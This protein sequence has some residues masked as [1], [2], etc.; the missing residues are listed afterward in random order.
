[1]FGNGRTATSGPGWC[2]IDGAFRNANNRAVSNVVIAT[3]GETS[4]GIVHTGGIAVSNSWSRNVYDVPDCSAAKWAW[5]NG[6]IM[7]F[8][9]FAGWRAVGQ[10]RRGA[11]GSSFERSR[12]GASLQRPPAAWRITSPRPRGT[13]WIIAR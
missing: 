7:Q 13:R 1:M 6:R 5:W 4:N 11:A 3:Q 10:D 12:M 2:L 8:L 9:D